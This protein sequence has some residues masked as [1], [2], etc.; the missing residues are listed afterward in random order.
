MPFKSYSRD[1]ERGLGAFENGGS[2]ESGVGRTV[3]ANALLDAECELGYNA[4]RNRTAAPRPC[5]AVHTGWVQ[6][7]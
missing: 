4:R 5:R 2:A 3:G 1:Q 7:G 6:D